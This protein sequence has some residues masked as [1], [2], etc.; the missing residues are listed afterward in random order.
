MNRTIVMLAVACVATLSASASTWHKT[1]DAA[2]AEAKKTNRMILVDMYADW[3][4]WCKRFEREVYPSEKFQAIA[5]NLVLLKLDTEDGKEGTDLARRWNVTSLPTFVMLSPDLVLAGYLRGY[6]PPDQ[7]VA[8]I[9]EAEDGWHEFRM[10]VRN[11]PADATE[12]ERMALTN[13]LLGRGDFEG[14]AARLKEHVGSANPAIRDD[15]YHKL[16]MVYRAQGKAEG[17]ISTARKGL[18][19]NS[20]GQKAEQLQ[21]LVAEVFMDQ[22]DYKAALAEYKKFK[23]LYPNSA[24]IG[25]VDYIVPQLEA[26]I[27]KKN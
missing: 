21:L 16:A 17:A 6:S 15:A 10:K 23:S 9:Q 19:L 12:A 5:K 3:C 1:L 24:M 14:A 8:R 26:E 13:E 7:F 11:E 2:Q 18:A 25:T 4:G 22:K 27:A 20:S